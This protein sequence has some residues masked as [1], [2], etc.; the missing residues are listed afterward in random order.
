MQ[1]F[2]PLSQEE[3]TRVRLPLE[4]QSSAGDR[5]MTDNLEMERQ[6]CVLRP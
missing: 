1:A 6:A 2:A 3:I 5:I 4:V